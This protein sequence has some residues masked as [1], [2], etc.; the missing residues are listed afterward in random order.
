M[1]AQMAQNVSTLAKESAGSKEVR[2]FTWAQFISLTSLQK[3]CTQSLL[4]VQPVD[5]G[6]GFP[7]TLY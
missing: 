1:Y 7:L 5:E 6:F 2:I 4:Q 3:R